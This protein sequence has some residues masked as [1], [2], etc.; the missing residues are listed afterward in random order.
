MKGVGL[1]LCAMY[2]GWN[3]RETFQLKEC[4]QPGDMRSILPEISTITDGTRTKGKRFAFR[5]KSVPM[6]DFQPSFS[7][8]PL[9]H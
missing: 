2:M 7:K 4:L 5:K 8:L 9:W 1:E 3:G 6:K